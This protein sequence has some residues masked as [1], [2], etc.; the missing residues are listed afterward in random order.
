MSGF[1]I[2]ADDLTRHFGGVRAVDGLRLRVRSGTVF[3]FLGP[4]GAG[5]TTTLHLLLGLLRPTRGTAI[6]AGEDVAA[7]PDAVRRRCGA[8]LEHN[9]LY[10]RLTAHDNLEFAARAH[11]LAK[12]ERDQRI[13][14][15]LEGMGLWDRRK[16][17]LGTWSRG[18]K[19]RLAIGRALLHRP[20][21]LFLDEP[22]AGFDPQ[23][24]AQL[25]QEMRALVRSA[26]TTVFLN[27]HNLHEAEELCDEVAVLRQGRVVAQG[28]PDALRGNVAPTLEVRGAGFTAPI[29]AKLRKRKEVAACAAEDG[30]L[31]ITLSGDHP[32]APLVRLLV[33]SGARVE[34]VVRPRSSLEESFLAIL[35]AKP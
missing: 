31:L 28:R 21:V 14:A 27:T 26:G 12:A 30:R 13:R 17:R 8:L 3:G 22:T 20:T 32:G 6:V 10:E 4:N 5:K 15:V 7:R 35:E 23:A 33:E 9:G 11:G 2:E 19:Q 34:E 25:R 16:D 1:A 29:V 24:A 18:M